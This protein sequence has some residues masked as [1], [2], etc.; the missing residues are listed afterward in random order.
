M[1]WRITPIAVA[2][3]STEPMLRSPVYAARPRIA[4]MDLVSSA[5]FTA[6]SAARWIAA[7]PWS[8]CIAGSP[9]A[10]SRL[11]VAG[12][13]ASR[14]VF[15]PSDAPP[16]AMIPVIAARSIAIT[17]SGASS[18]LSPAAAPARRNAVPQ[19]GPETPPTLPADDEA[20]LLEHGSHARLVERVVVGDDDLEPVAQRVA[21]VAVPDD[22]VEL[23]EV[24]RVVD[25]RRGHRL[26]DEVDV[27]ERRLC[28]ADLLSFAGRDAGWGYGARQA[29]RSASVTY[30]PGRAAERLAMT[31]VCSP[32]GSPRDETTRIASLKSSFS[33]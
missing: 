18:V 3:A 26:E 19:I 28:H 14:S 21:E 15:S 22:R 8:P 30:A 25:D 29:S 6:T 23:G 5:A 10:A 4:S 24:L 17:S 2:P 16:R 9:I 11:S 32:S 27:V 7:T 33:V 31:V 20:D 12:T 1:A 13:S